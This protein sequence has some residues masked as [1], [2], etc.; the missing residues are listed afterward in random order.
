MKTAASI[1]GVAALAVL[2]C[3]AI[4]Q[5]RDG[6]SQRQGGPPPIF[7]VEVP[8]SSLNVIAGAPTS[9][10][11]VLSILGRTD[12]PVGLEI[13]G[14]QGELVPVPRVEI[15][16]T[17]PVE[18]KIAGL[19]PNASYTYSLS[20]AG[21]R[22]EGRFATAPSPGGAF[23][24]A[25]QADSHLDANSDLR[26][27]ERTLNN[28]TK[29][30]PDFL[31]DLG[32]TFMVDK[33][34]NYQESLKQYQAQRYWFSL[35]G[36]QMSVFLCLGNHDGET[37]WPTRGQPGVTEWSQQQREAY[38]PVIRQNGFYSGAPQKGLWYSWVWGDA[39]FIV[40]DPFVATSNKVRGE[41]DGWGWT[42]GQQQY[43]WLEETLKNSRSK[44]KFVFIHHLVGGFGGAAAR[45]GVEAAERFEWGDKEAYPKKRAG[46]A[47][48]IHALMVKYGVTAMFHGH[49]HFYARQ[50]KDGVIYLLAPQ[51]SQGRGG[52]INS[53]KE[54][55]YESGV[56]L[57]GSGHIRV[58]VSPEKVKIEFVKSLAGPDNG[59]V[60]DTVEAKA[61]R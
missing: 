47:E 10:S 29:D 55:G 56:I 27:Y 22:V 33:Y 28:I 53:A 61:R 36:S 13:R 6:G 8:A 9:N 38:F 49:D 60:V 1:A 31:V 52:S 48:P 20:Q 3:G 15:T 43:S 18:V 50:E 19:K 44:H 12:S 21:S 42:L 46:W 23:T 51:P 26:V 25:I 57:G 17:E 7:R 14:L 16:E 37:G 30:R 2:L 54:Y 58:A 41:D 45:G 35:V 11:I 34:P 24:F 5:G 40:L 32:D 39:T 4:G 59:T